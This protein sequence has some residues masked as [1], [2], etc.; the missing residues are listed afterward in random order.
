ME[1]LSKWNGNFI[2]FSSKSTVQY[3]NMFSTIQTL[4]A[5]L[6]CP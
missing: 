6:F 5:P 3:S 1:A 4:H 2:I